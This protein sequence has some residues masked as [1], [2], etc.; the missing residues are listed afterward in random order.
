MLAAGGA[1]AYASVALRP[2]GQIS[3][4]TAAS[5]KPSFPLYP[6]W[7]WYDEFY[8]AH[9]GQI[10]ARGS[11]PGHPFHMNLRIQ[12]RGGG[13]DLHNYHITYEYGRQWRVVDSVRGVDRVFD[14][15]AYVDDVTAAEIVAGQIAS[16]VSAEAGIN[17]M[18][19]ALGE[20]AVGDAGNLAS[21]LA[22]LAEACA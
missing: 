9:I 21:A 3:G 17:A 13:Y 6:H 19:A 16:D 4:L 22:E 10:E 14:R 12:P 11:E 7:S 20:Q 18:A 1:Q 5:P 8:Q 2:N 15:S